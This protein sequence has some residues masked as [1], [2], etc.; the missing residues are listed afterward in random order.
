MY[1]LTALHTFGLEANS[2]RLTTIDSL[3]SLFEIAPTLSKIPHLLLGEGSNT[4]F[5]GDFEGLIIKNALKGIH[6]SEDEDYF[7][8]HVASGEN[9][10][11]LV[12]LCMAKRI[13]GFEN[14]ALI[15]GTVGA[16]PIQNIGAYGVE[17]ERFVHSVEFLDLGTQMMGYFNKKECEFAYRDSRFKRELGK[18][19]ITSVNFALPKHN[20]L[21]TSYGPLAQ[22]SEPSP[23]DVFKTVIATRKSKLPDPQVLGNAGSFF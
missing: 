1:S 6:I 7:H 10:H 17:I 12:Q 3:D 8:L 9:W 21:V 4:I 16:S 11:E 18:R 20:H 13:Y 2:N 22:L 15:P 5:V 19:I 23:E 14:L